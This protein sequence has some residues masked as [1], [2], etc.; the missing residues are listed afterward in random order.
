MSKVTPFPGPTPSVTDAAL[1][2]LE[3]QGE[4]MAERA[5]KLG[6]ADPTIE[7]ITDYDRN[8]FGMPVRF[9][10]DVT[11]PL[12]VLKQEINTIRAELANVLATLE[13]PGV[14]G[15]TRRHM[16][17]SRLRSLRAH[18]RFDRTERKMREKR[19]PTQQD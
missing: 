16:A 3:R 17:H 10:I 15:N 5:R 2:D 4:A 11:V 6:Q 1:R 7:Q 9:E 12:P 14:A 19:Q 13:Q 18:L 8:L